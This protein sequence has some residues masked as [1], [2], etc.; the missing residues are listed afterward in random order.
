MK[1]IVSLFLAALIIMSFSLSSCNEAEPRTAE[2]T[3]KARIGVILSD[4][5]EGLLKIE[6]GIIAQLYS[7]G[8]TKNSAD[9]VVKYNDEESGWLTNICRSMSGGTFDAVICV[10]AEAAKCFLSL[11]SKTPCFIC[12]IGSAYEIGLESESHDNATAVISRFPTEELLNFSE[13]ITKRGKLG[14]IYCYNDMNSAD[15]VNSVCQYLDAK[16]VDY[17]LRAVGEAEDVKGVTDAL[18]SDGAKAVFVPV[19]SVVLE[20]M[21]ALVTACNAKKIPV[22]CADS[23]GVEAGGLAAFTYSPKNI[24][25]RIAGMA[26]NYLKGEKMR[27]IPFAQSDIDNLVVNEDSLNVLGIILPEETEYNVVRVRWVK[28]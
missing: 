10:G 27:N 15:T 21:E 16:G 23:S 1:K 2:V 20:G 7:M 4:K 17:S 5:S 6:E 9:V 22:L 3:K 8:Y 11:K 24:G 13:D 12:G 26:G 19:D 25:K 14:L 28:E 18:I